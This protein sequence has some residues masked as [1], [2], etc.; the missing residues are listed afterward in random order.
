MGGVGGVGGIG[1]VGGFSVG[2]ER[3]GF[4]FAIPGV[5]TT[6]AW[7]SGS[8]WHAAWQPASDTEALNGSGPEILGPPQLIPV[9][10]AQP[11]LVPME[12]VLHH[13]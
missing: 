4:G 12:Y 9:C 13:A 10:S 8:L 6:M 3:G 2:H 1:G 5:G 7:H 11:D